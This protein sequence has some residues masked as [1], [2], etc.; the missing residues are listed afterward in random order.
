MIYIEMEDVM[1]FL[2]LGGDKRYRYLMK[3]L[4]NEHNIFCVGFNNLSFDADILNINEV[5]LNLF[6]VILL[7]I[8]G[9]NDNMEIKTEIRKY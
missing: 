9:I 3:D 4:S 5:D 1:K 6:D 2:F 8:S 7:P